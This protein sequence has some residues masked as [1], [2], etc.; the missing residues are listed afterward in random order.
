VYQAPPPIPAAPP[1]SDTIRLVPGTHSIGW[2]IFWA[3]VCIPGLGQ[4]D[5]KQKAKAA[6]IC[7]ATLLLAFQQWSFY[8]ANGFIDGNL[9][10]I[11]LALYV[12]SVIDAGMIAY[13]L[14]RGKAVHRWR[15]F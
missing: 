10:L 11:Q 12:A 7:G 9:R 2:P 8:S 6:L 14:N 15:F 3:L 13:R 4:W 5:N 1:A